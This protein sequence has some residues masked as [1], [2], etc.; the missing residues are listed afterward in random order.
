MLW[1]TPAA[2]LGLGLIA[3]PIA[4][5]LLVRQQGRRVHFPS[6]RFVRQSQPAAFRRRT[7][8]DALLLLCRV[9]I[10]SA[11]VMA[12]AGPVLQ[13]PS[14]AAAYADRLARAVVLEPGAPR[15]ASD[16]VVGDA[17]ISE[18]F[19][20]SRVGDAVA[21]AARWLAKQPPAAREVV[22]VGALR[23]GS[24]TAAHL[25][26]VPASAGIRFVPTTTAP[27]ARVVTL[28]VL[29]ARGR[30][31]SVGSGGASG[32]VIQRQQVRLDDESTRV[33]EGDEVAVANDL[34]R[35]VSAPAEQALADA[36]LRAALGA[37]LRWSDPTKRVLVVWDGA[38]EGVVQRMLDGASVVRLDRP[39][40]VS[41]AA[42]A[43][44]DAVER[45]TA[46]PVDGLEPVRISAEQLQLWSRPPGQVPADAPPVDEGDG[47]WFWGFALALLVLE[48]WLRRAG[49]RPA[50][51][52]RAVE[53]RVA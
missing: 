10:V 29:R 26:A 47:R 42:S 43:V 3:L 12:L 31:G 18:T 1:L 39:V 40:P 37:G 52:E 2:L 51:V 7:I 19:V 50:V 33:F 17:F 16:D 46:A 25:S 35:I 32:L 27:A 53:A 30:R 14:R 24:L 20:R 22:F 49:T 44:T 13:T 15:S 38:D 21:D 4:I 45:L 34:V 41:S 8:Q 23:R 5:H 36:A 48:H 9:A 11:A 6:L 28:P